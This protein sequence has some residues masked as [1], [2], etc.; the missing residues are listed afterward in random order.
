[1]CLGCHRNQGQAKSS[2][3]T[4][5][6]NHVAAS[7]TSGAFGLNNEIEKNKSMPD[8]ASLP[9]IMH[10]LL[11]VCGEGADVRELMKGQARLEMRYSSFQSNWIQKCQH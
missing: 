11:G 8:L 2:K 6:P 9:I 3:Q 10:S 1:M 5:A 4:T 7:F